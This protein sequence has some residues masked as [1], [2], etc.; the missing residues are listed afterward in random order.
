MR[1]YAAV[2]KN[3]TLKDSESAE[4]LT[5]PYRIL[6]ESYHKFGSE[7]K[8][9][10]VYF[11]KSGPYHDPAYGTVPEKNPTHNSPGTARKSSFHR[12]L[13]HSFPAKFK[14][15]HKPRF[16]HTLPGL[17][18]RIQSKTKINPTQKVVE[19]HVDC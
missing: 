7:S 1:K 17:H 10:P 15:E 2:L 18:P 8:T 6:S 19:T 9:I 16:D 3:P 11:N 4:N 5:E 13:R 14:G 12:V